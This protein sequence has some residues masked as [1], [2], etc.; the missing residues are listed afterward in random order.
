MDGSQKIPQRWLG[1]LADQV[2]RKGDVKLLALCLAAW[3]R[4]LQGYDEADNRYDINDPLSD[5]LKVQLVVDAA[6][7]RDRQTCHTRAQALVQVAPVFGQHRHL[8]TDDFVEQIGH[9]LYLLN[10]EGVVQTL[11]PI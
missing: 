4:Y 11:R 2:N 6:L 5:Q 8:L 3:L 10:T 9:F 7:D 1:T